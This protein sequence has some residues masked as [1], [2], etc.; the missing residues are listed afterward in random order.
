MS[1]WPTAAILWSSTTAGQTSPTS[2]SSSSSDSSDDPSEDHRARTRLPARHHRQSAVEPVRPGLRR[3]AEHRPVEMGGRRRGQ[4]RGVRLGRSPVLHRPCRPAARRRIRPDPATHH[5]P[6]GLAGCRGAARAGALPHYLLDPRQGPRRRERIRARHGPALRQPRAQSCANPR[7][8]SDSFPEA[9]AANGSR[10]TPAGP[11]TRNHHRSNGLRRRHRPNDTDGSIGRYPMPNST[12]SWAGS[13]PGLP[14]S[15]VL[16]SPRPR[17]LSICMAACPTSTGSPPRR[18]AST[19]FSPTRLSRAASRA[20]WRPGFSS[21]ASSNSTSRTASPLDAEADCAGVGGFRHTL[22]RNDRHRHYKSRARW[23][24]RRPRRGRLGHSWPGGAGHAGCRVVP[25]PGIL[26]EE[27]NAGWML[28]STTPPGTG[29][30]GTDSTDC[31]ST[32]RAFSATSVS[33]SPSPPPACWPA[34]CLPC[35]HDRR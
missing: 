10:S 27:I 4:S 3:R 35:K 12:H 26:A 2:P 30:T 17:P 28:R 8:A 18:T 15:T 33:R 34:H 32:R 16:P 20:S 25:C 13:P 11:S 6:G 19:D 31:E 22:V 23:R 5:R 24:G 7:S 1:R 9:V 21:L 14:V 29:S